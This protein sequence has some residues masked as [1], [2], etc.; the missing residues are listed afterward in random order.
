MVRPLGILLVVLA[1][2]GW[3]ASTAPGPS[4]K[5]HES[6][7]GDCDACHLP[8]KGLPNE[9]CLTC[10]TELKKFHASVAAQKCVACH[11]D[12]KGHDADMTKRPALASFDHAL[13]GMPLVGA[14]KNVTCAKCHT[15]P[16]TEMGQSCASCH[17]DPHQGTLG[18]TCAAC[19]KSEAWKPALHPITEHK[20]SMQGG[21]AK[22]D[23]VS[24]HKQGKALADTV[25]CITCHERAH[26]GTTAPC[27][28][29]HQVE[30]WKPAHFDHS[31]CTCTLPKK[32]QTVGCLGCHKDF[33]FKSAPQLCSGC[34][35]KERKHEPLGECSLCHSAVSWKKNEL[36][37]NKRTKFALTGQHLK[38]ACEGCHPPQGASM[39]FRG[40]P[41]LCEGCHQ[42]QG[43]KAHG[44]FG[45]CLKC[46]STDGFDKS[47]FDHATT[48]FPLLGRHAKLACKDCHD[49]KTQGYPDMPVK[50]AELPFGSLRGALAWAAGADAMSD[51]PA[52]A[53][54]S[55]APHPKEAAC[56]HCHA[57]P[58][59]GSTKAQGECSSCHT[60]EA[61]KPPTFTVERHAATP[62]P[63]TGKHATTSCT[64]CHTDSKLNDAPSQCA[65][66]HVDRHAGRLGT[67]CARCH[68]TT[69]FKPVTGFDHAITGFNLTGVH[70]KVTC[71]SCHEGKRGEAMVAA[72][73][74]SACTTCH[75]SRHGAEVGTQ[76]VTC[77]DPL[78][79]PFSKA[80]G[81][82]FAHEKTGFPLER[83][84]AVQPC[85]ACHPA[86]GPPPM[87]ACGSCHKD[88]HAG[89]LGQ[90]CEDCHVADRWRLV[91]FDHDRTAWPLRG[92]HFVTPCIKC[93]TGQR[94]VGLTDECW[95]CHSNK[96]ALGKAMR[97]AE[98]PF[99][100]LD[101]SGCHTSQWRW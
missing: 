59:Q 25:P 34:H 20:L 82:A 67:E 86:S 39:K 75:V 51:A 93:H 57:D 50:K 7:E 31:F 73:T 3:K 88:P 85:T 94:W 83:R 69:A 60:F 52:F 56:S 10:H 81:M 30:A 42:K 4:G 19:H 64:L 58:H 80:R 40:V 76:C 100:P 21:H 90:G 53:L 79:G 68:N 96:A 23:C 8:F 54:A 9:K 97:P 18:A 46:H 1:G 77:H 55:V 14:H 74:P 27:E 33:D 98:H 71:R 28:G 22:L 65:Q 72:K 38:V 62:F 101:C 92:K 66:C 13:T 41:T 24:C 45:A 99:G 78:N 5:G 70:A 35:D 36:D 12:H 48:G 89:Q 49:E 61:W 29:C 11:T 17:K 16:I 91:R 43:D 2:Q 47:T 84:H 95:D 15:K 6:V 32:H 44:N 87:S 63:L 37:H 26:G